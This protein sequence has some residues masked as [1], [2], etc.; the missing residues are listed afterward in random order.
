[1]PLP[2]IDASLE[3]IEYCLDQLDVDGFVI[4][5]S[6]DGGYLGDKHFAPLLQELDKR[7]AV[8]FIHP[9]QPPY[10]IPRVAPAFSTRVSV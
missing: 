5:T 6:Y 2:D 3:E 8:A 4:F 7:K 10:D 1:L 9:N